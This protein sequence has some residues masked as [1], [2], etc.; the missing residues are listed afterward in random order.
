MAEEGTVEVEAAAVRLA[1]KERM[2]EIIQLV[3]M[4]VKAI[5]EL[6]ERYA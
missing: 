5:R 2:V 4:R 3:T 6:V 1:R